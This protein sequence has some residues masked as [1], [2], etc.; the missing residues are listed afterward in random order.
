MQTGERTA[1]TG[2]QHHEYRGDR[3][4]AKVPTERSFG[5]TFAAVFALLSA[6]QLYR[7]GLAAGAV[8]T[9]VLSLG[10]L[11]AAY[12][13]PAALR[14][15]NIVW[16]K[17]GLLLHRIVNPVIMGVLFFG[18]FTPIGAGMRLFGA[19]LLRLR[20]PPENGSYWILRAGET[21]EPGSMTNQ[22]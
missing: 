1:V 4:E 11:A 22:F 5:L 7:H 17:F 10:F 19:D 6:L 3:S 21:T 2:E 14:P 12:V 9:A 15:L 8:I 20:R 16:M 13:A 18:V